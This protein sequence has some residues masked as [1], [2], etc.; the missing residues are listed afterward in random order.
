M[1][2]AAAMAVLFG[3]LVARSPLFGVLAIASFGV[4]AAALRVGLLAFA[5]PALMLLPWFVILEG[6]APPLVGTLIAAVGAGSLLLCV[7]PLRFESPLVPFAAFGFVVV[8]LVNAI[9]VTDPDQLVQA[10]KYLVFVA[11]AIAVSSVGAADLM[12]KL[13]MPLLGSCLAAMTVHLL[14]IAAGVGSSSSY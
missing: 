7:T 6:V 2:G 11:V 14:L 9:F 3:V 13:K 1:A 10:A 5:V 4:A 12:P 8:V